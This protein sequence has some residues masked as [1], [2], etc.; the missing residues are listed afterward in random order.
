MVLVQQEIYTHTACLFNPKIFISSSVYLFCVCKGIR[1]MKTYK[2]MSSLKY[3]S[4]CVA[5]VKYLK[6]GEKC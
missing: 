5:S 2:V 3:F 4:G 6:H 1:K